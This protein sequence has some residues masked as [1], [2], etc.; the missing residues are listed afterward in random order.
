MKNKS[1][2]VL[3]NSRLLLS[4]PSYQRPIDNGRIKRILTNFNEDLVNLVKVSDRNG[5]YYVFDGQHTLAA[6]KARNNGE[7]LMVQ[8]KVYT[9]LT[10]V[11]EALLFAEQN[12]ISRQV[13]ASSKFKALHFAGDEGIVKMVSIAKECGIFIDF[14]KGKG[15]NKI[16]A[17]SKIYKIY[18]SCNEEEFK[19]YLLLIKETWNGQ[20]ESFNTEILGGVFN[21]Y[22]KYN[23]EY[24][25]ALFIKK[26]SKISI[27]EICRESSQ[28]KTGG[29][30]RYERYIFA[31]YN[32]NLSTGRIIEKN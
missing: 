8:C 3:L 27:N 14:S 28:F 21:F 11:D 19:D 18:N 10:E 17:V 22:K 15:V 4:S 5:K 7:N 6:L 20:A 24:K 25:R 9:G 26:L 23:N 13:G 30:S 32:L 29:D 12:G 1:N 31:K 2:I 16:V